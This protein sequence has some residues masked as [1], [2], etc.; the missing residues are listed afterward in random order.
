[1]KLRVTATTALVIAAASLAVGA[2]ARSTAPAAKTA[3]A[4]VAIIVTGPARVGGFNV[5]HLNA[6]DAMCKQYDFDCTIVDN[7]DYA[8]ANQ[9]LERLAASGNNLVIA[10]SN[11]F[12]DALYEVAPK[13]RNT[14]FVM[15]SDL[16]GTKGNKNLAAFVQRWSEF[17]YLGG[18]AAA[19]L[20]K[21]G[22]MGYVIGQ[23]IA[24][25]KRMMGG[26]VQGAR[27]VN[28][29]AKVLVKYTNSFVDASLAKQAALAEIAEG[30]DVLTGIA[31]GA[32][33]GI[34]Q[35][36]QE[37]NVTY[38]GYFADEYKTAPK[39]IPTSMTINGPRIYSQIGRLFSTKQ[40]KARVYLG[41]VADGSIRLAPLRGVPKAIA[42]KI[43]KAQADVK[44]GKIK[45]KDRLYG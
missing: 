14:W 24:T 19:R 18:V 4:K 26:F 39:N 35:A 36:V 13:F 5:T 27:S 44:S 42:K 17:G 45:V 10:N 15:T 23:P 12:A 8:S 20:S 41:T 30:A 29:K 3:T 7:V 21:T 28:P 16:P 34:I 33:P 9:T 1:M 31:G 32:A 43:L 38:I 2:S 22:I 6:Y 25:G 40:L 37:K 11:G